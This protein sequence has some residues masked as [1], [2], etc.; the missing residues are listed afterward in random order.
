MQSQKTQQQINT[1]KPEKRPKWNIRSYERRLAA[2]EVTH[3]S[4]WDDLDH[5]L[6]LAGGGGQERLGKSPSKEGE[7]GRVRK[8]EN[9]IGKFNSFTWSFALIFPAR[10]C[11]EKKTSLLLQSFDLC[12]YCLQISLNVLVNCCT[13]FNFETYFSFNFMYFKYFPICFD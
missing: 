9:G 7:G 1:R 8:V 12:E 3:I 10:F 13:F 6:E 11:D 2:I 4:R 5:F